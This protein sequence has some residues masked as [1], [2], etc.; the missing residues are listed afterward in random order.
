MI[1]SSSQPP[2]LLTFLVGNLGSKLPWEPKRLVREPEN[3]KLTV[4][5]IGLKLQNLALWVILQNTKSEIKNPWAMHPIIFPIFGGW[6][7]FE[8]ECGLGKL[9]SYGTKKVENT[10]D[11]FYDLA[12]AQKRELELED[13]VWQTC[14]ERS[15]SRRRKSIR[16]VL[17][18]HYVATQPSNNCT[19]FHKKKAPKK[20]KI[21]KEF[22]F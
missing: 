7:W 10:I 8:S 1:F 19:N 20:S 12:R 11:S 5:Q 13:P 3:C 22:W 4:L 9:I 21:G 2:P 18:K 16:K 6:V 14:E 17:G 15:S